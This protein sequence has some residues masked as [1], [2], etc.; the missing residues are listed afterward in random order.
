MVKE[1]VMVNSSGEFRIGETSPND[2]AAVEPSREVS[3][4]A[5]EV[6]ELDVTEI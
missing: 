3:S 5:E 1:G 6:E 2:D 4:E